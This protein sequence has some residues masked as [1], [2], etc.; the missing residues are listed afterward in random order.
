MRRIETKEELIDHLTRVCSAYRKSY[1]LYGTIN[2]ILQ[3]TGGILGSTAVLAI[4]PVI[5]VFN[6]AL[7]VTPVVIGIIANVTK[8]NDKKILLKSHHRKYKVLL[9]Y[10]Q[11]QDKFTEQ[12]LIKDVVRQITDIHTATDYT[13][14]IEWYIRRRKLNG[15]D[16]EADEVNK[17]KSKG[18]EPLDEIKEPT[19]I[20]TVNKPLNGH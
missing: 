11:R 18:F 19:I 16:I 13:E 5:P 17:M 7:S 14:P 8:I 15:Y 10:V 9:S 6:A 1:K 2:K 4:V 12:Q 3:I 20:K